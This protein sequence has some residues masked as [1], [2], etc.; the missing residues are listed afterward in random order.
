MPLQI[1]GEDI[2]AGLEESFDKEAQKKSQKEWSDM[3]YF[4]IPMG[5]VLLTSLLLEAVAIYWSRALARNEREAEE[6][7]NRRKAA[8]AAKKE[9]SLSDLSEKSARDVNPSDAFFN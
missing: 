5:V 6:A 2:A 3:L 1:P 9:G 4:F 8:A 7:A